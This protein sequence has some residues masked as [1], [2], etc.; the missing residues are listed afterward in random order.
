MTPTDESQAKASSTYSKAPVSVVIPCFRAASTIER[1]VLS[2]MQQ[3]VQPAEVIVVDDFSDDSDTSL[4]LNR[5]S[6]QFPTALKVIWLSKNSGP[7]V[8]R[9]SGWEVATQE[10]VAFLDADDTWAPRKLELQLPH[11]QADTSV[12]M[13]GHRMEVWPGSRISPAA[14]QSG[15]DVERVSATR[16]LFR[17]MIPTPSVILRRE[18]PYRF[19]PERRYGEDYE[20]WLRIALGYGSFVF[21]DEP[22]AF[23]YKAFYGEA[24]LSS[25]L[26][27][28]E[29]GQTSVYVALFRERAFTWPMLAVLLG[30]AKVRYVRRLAITR[31]RRSLGN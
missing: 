17:N 13:S 11:M 15:V 4:A 2:A 31:L 1:A 28:M 12:A 29:R 20:L 16:L 21:L 3:S 24:G 27:N 8:A 5:L 18:V 10:F 26:K 30:W 9:N 23:S 6:D 25:E 7:S 14:E 19:D 22:L